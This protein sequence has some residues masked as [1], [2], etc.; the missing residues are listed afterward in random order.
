MAVPFAAFRRGATSGVAHATISVCCIRATRISAPSRSLERSPGSPPGVRPD[1]I[2]L[3]RAMKSSPVRRFACCLVLHRHGLEPRQHQREAAL[4]GGAVGDH[5]L[6]M[7][8]CMNPC[9]WVTF[10]STAQS[11]RKNRIDA[12]ASVHQIHRGLA[13]M[14]S[15]TR[16]AK[17]VPTRHGVRKVVGMGG[18]FVDVYVNVNLQTLRPASRRPGAPAS[19]RRFLHCASSAKS[20]STPLEVDALLFQRRAVA[21]STSRF[22]QLGVSSFRLSY[23]SMSSRLGSRRKPQALT[24]QARGRGFGRRGFDPTRDGDREALVS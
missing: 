7:P 17:H 2:T 18:V 8:P 1:L 6:V 24:A 22:R 16:S 11:P 4:A 14:V 12:T 5:P 15:R 13:P 19:P 9:C 10:S 23:M 20:P 3:A 21:G